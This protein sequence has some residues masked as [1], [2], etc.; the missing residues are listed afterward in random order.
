MDHAFSCLT[1]GG[2]LVLEVDSSQ[3]EKVEIDGK[4]VGLKPIR[5]EPKSGQFIVVFRI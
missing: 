3:K 2:Q 5:L 1:P 4:D